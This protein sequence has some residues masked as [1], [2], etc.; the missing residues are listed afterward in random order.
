MNVECGRMSVY[1]RGDLL[2]P[3]FCFE[4]IKYSDEI[5]RNMSINNYLADRRKDDG[6]VHTWL[7]IY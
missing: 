3:L 2:S 5:N 7:D 4:K 6:G 1:F